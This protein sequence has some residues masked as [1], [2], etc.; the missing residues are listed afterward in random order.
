M[1]DANVIS[2]DVLFAQS[3]AKIALSRSS[4]TL[5]ISLSPQAEAK[6]KEQAAAKGKDPTAYASELVED[7]VTKPTLDEILAPFRKQVADA[8]MSDSELDEFYQRLRDGDGSV[9][10]N[11]GR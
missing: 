6:L 8:G 11:S 2:Y 1:P 7:A 4:M 10:A 5:S 9:G 3:Y